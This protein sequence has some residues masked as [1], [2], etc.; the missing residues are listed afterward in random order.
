MLVP[1]LKERLFLREVS[2]KV[3]V[4]T[5]SL[6]SQAVFLLGYHLCSTHRHFSAMTL[7]PKNVPLAFFKE[8]ASR[9]SVQPNLFGVSAQE[10]EP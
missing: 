1:Q 6:G 3:C 7:A 5:R 9:P 2:R 10:K 8:Q 4:R